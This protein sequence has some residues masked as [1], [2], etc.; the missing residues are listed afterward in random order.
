VS[1]LVITRGLPGCGKTT[2]AR[3]WVAQDPLGRSRV[4]RDDLG[5]LMHGRRFYGD[6]KLFGPT[7]D[8][9][10]TAQY[11]MIVHLLSAGRD[12]I[13]DDTNLD[14]E[15][16]LRLLDVV[17]QAGA[18]VQVVD[19]RGLPLVTVLERNAQRAGTSAFVPEHV[20]RDMWER[21]VAEMATA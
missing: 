3:A 21:Y 10:T 16:L 17:D 20:I 12:V 15:R 13:N 14:D 1:T 8:A 7:E 9:I 19:M 5:Q 18:D 2:Y 6:E 11:A 4:N